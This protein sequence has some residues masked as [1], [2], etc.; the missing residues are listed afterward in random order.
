MDRAVHLDVGHIH[1]GHVR[2]WP[3]IHWNH[4]AVVG[5][6]GFHVVT[7]SMDHHRGH[8]RLRGDLRLIEY[9]VSSGLEAVL[10]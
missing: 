6:S 1:G 4:R 10:R 2:D 5:A 9:H 8:A 7:R 3:D